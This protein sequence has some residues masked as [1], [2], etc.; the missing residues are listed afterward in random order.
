MTHSIQKETVVP[1]GRVRA[2]RVFWV[3]VASMTWALCAKTEAITLLRT[4]DPSANTTEPTGELGGSG[5][6]YTGTFGAFL[7]TPIAPHHFIEARHIGVASNVL[8]Y[9]GVNYT[10]THWFDDPHSDLRIYEVAE[11]IPDLRTAL[12]PE[13]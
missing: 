3:L 6:Q 12:Q 1:R 11:N 4:G 10:I 5:W 2:A 13:R 7:G 9:H 8:T